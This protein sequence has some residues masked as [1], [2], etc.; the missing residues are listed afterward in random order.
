MA[1]AP[2]SRMVLGIGDPQGRKMVID[3]LETLK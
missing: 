3:Y 1:M 2:G